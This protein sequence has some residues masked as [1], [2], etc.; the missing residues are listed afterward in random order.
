MLRPIAHRGLHTGTVGIVEN[1]QSAFVAAIA[2]GTAIE[3]D[4]RRTADSAA[5]VFHDRELERLTGHHGPVAA[6]SACELARIAYAGSDDLILSLDEVLELVGD[7]VPLFVE[8][9]SDWEEPDSAFLHA[10]CRSLAQHKGQIA[11]MSFDPAVL[12]AI[13][14]I[15]PPLLR[16]IVACRYAAADAPGNALSR[17]RMERLSDLLDCG[18]AAPDFVNYRVSDL[19]T[20]VLRYVREVQGLPVLAWTVRTEAELALAATWSDAAVFEAVAPL[21]VARAF[22]SG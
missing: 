2:A 19:P 11:V 16:G 10:A 22:T 13:R 20:P 15:A 1:S 8:I 3:C 6:R 21:R 4:V 5:V 7:R 12:V 18:A 17:G 14:E 9:K